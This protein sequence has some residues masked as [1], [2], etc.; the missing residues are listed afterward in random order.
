MVC[1]LTLLLEYTVVSILSRNYSL[2]IIEFKKKIWLR[3]LRKI[4][5]SSEVIVFIRSIFIVPKMDLSHELSSVSN[6]LRTDY[7]FLF[8]CRDAFAI[9]KLRDAN[10]QANVRPV[11]AGDVV[12]GENRYNPYPPS[13]IARYRRRHNEAITESRIY[14]HRRSVSAIKNRAC[15]YVK[16]F[17]VSLFTVARYTL[18]FPQQ[19][20]LPLFF[21]RP[22][23]SAANPLQPPLA[24]LFISAILAT[25]V[26][27]MEKMLIFVADLNNPPPFP[28]SFSLARP[29]LILL[30]YFELGVVAVRYYVAFL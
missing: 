25:Q 22:P 5:L 21:F 20:R 15:V 2:L 8:P 3:K 9:F 23:P 1:V 29:P 12:S 13:A 18:I 7:I 6:N 14:G 19:I 26:G 30:H 10:T 17:N 28:S 11:V 16:S 24:C 4:S 27:R